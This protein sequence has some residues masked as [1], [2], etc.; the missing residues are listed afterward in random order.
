MGTVYIVGVGM[1]TSDTITGEAAQL[2]AGCDCLIGAQ[3][4]LQGIANPAPRRFTLVLPAEI[5]QVIEQNPQFHQVVVAMSGDSGFFSGAK[6]LAALLKE[7]GIPVELRCGVSSLQY[8]CA[9]IQISWEDAKIV[10]VHG[11]EANPVGSVAC[12]HKT[13]FLTGTNQPVEQVCQT[14]TRHGLGELQAWAGENLSYPQERIVQGTVAQLAGQTFGGLAVLLVENPTPN[15]PPAHLPDE[16]FQRGKAPMTK[17]EVRAVSVA[18]L[19]LLPWETAY[20]VGAGT[21]SVA[22]EMALFCPQGQVYAVEKNPEALA[23]LHENRQA[24]ALHNMCIVEGEAPAALAPLPPPDAVFIGGSSG[25]LREIM[26]LC[27]QK[28]PTA[29][30]VINAITLETVCQAVKALKELSLVETEI[31]Q[32]SVARAKSIGNY[33]MMMGQNP[34][35]IISGKGGGASGSQN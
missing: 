9:K 8:F 33:H 22:G 15:Q 10:S 26:A 11:R 19:R 20:D 30:F 13:F 34:V 3:R 31:V 29:R 23:L 5:V 24:L 12:N 25:S 21:G 7:K 35:Y 18:K 32:L 4:V 17:E 27:L 14:L 6:K 2:I 16:A 28:N 1:G